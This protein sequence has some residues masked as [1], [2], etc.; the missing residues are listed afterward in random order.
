MKENG[1]LQVGGFVPLTTVEWEDRLCAVVFVQGCPWCCPYCHNPELI[2]RVPGAISWASLTV[3]LAERTGF[4][5]AV[6]FSGGEPTCQVALL[7]ALAQVREMGFATAVHTN[8][9][10][11]ELLEAIV[12]EGLADYL[13]MDVKAPVEKYARVTGVGESGW[14]AA[15]SIEVIVES[16]IDHEFRTTWHPDLL[17]AG[18]LRAIAEWLKRSGARAYYIQQFRGEGCADTDLAASDALP[19]EIPAD[20]AREIQNMFPRFGVRSA[21]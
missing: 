20:L 7:A 3:L 16:G 1:E 18:D 5:D 21:S 9:C 15:R 19:A 10:N 4:L 17:D 11:P 2:P 13:A 6:V 12:A 8:G 14:A